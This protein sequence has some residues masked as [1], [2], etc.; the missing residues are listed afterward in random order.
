MLLSKPVQKESKIQP[1]F[2][3]AFL[4]IILFMGYNFSDSGCCHFR[5]LAGITLGYALSRAYI[6]ASLGSVN[7]AYTTRVRRK[8][9]RTIDVYVFHFIIDCQQASLV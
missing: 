4:G 8:L 1:I 7:R 3:F 2:G 5:L 6:Q 9:M